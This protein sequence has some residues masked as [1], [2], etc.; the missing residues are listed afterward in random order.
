M[1]S[2]YRKCYNMFAN[3]VLKVNL[4]CTI[5]AR[6]MP[7]NLDLLNKDSSASGSH[8]QTTMTQAELRLWLQPAVT[9]PCV[10]SHILRYSRNHL[11]IKSLLWK[12]WW[13]KHKKHSFRKSQILACLAMKG[14]IWFP[15]VSEELL[16]LNCLFLHSL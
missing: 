5:V 15:L 8:S 16:N 12:K 13:C 11:S 3:M 9:K 2:V 14:Y 7:Q 6:R 10:S 4:W 1:S